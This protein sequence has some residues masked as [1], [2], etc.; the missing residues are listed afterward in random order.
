MSNYNNSGADS[1]VSV[2]EPPRKR[3]LCRISKRAL[4]FSYQKFLFHVGARGLD[5]CNLG[6]IGGGPLPLISFLFSMRPAKSIS[7]PL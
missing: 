7:I 6:L 3:D 1:T 5:E 2:P 4:N